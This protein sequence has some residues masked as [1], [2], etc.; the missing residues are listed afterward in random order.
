MGAQVLWATLDIPAPPARLLADW[1]RDLQGMALA[2]GDVEQLPLAR[3]QARWP[4][5]RH[6]VQQV[7][8]WACSLGLPPLLN[9]EYLALMACRGAHYH[10]D[11]AQYSG[12]AFCNV[13]LSDDLG[14]DLH[15]AAAGLR[16]P[17][18]RGTVVV[19][20][21]GQPHAVVARQRSGFEAADFPV[22]QALGPVFLTWE[23][24][25]EEPQVA[26]ALGVVWGDALAP[27]AVPPAEM[28]ALAGVAVRVCPAT[29][30]WLLV[31]P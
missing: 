26:Q 12:L 5:Y 19:F 31:G 3:A 21:T 29:G 1:Q 16:I 9:S 4:D 17:L 24:P 23:L 20:D 11:A 2:P 14:L 13:F 18:R 8:N 15:F 10:H 7:S 27:G 30:R 22:G 28:L 25:I 6:C